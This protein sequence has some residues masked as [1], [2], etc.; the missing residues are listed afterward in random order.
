MHISDVTEFSGSHFHTEISALSNAPELYNGI[1][2]VL[3]DVRK[4]FVM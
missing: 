4:Y 2:N 1:A 3:S